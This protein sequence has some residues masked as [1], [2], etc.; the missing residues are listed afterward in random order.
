MAIIEK[1]KVKVK[2]NFRRSNFPG[3]ENGEIGG[4]GGKQRGEK[5][6]KNGESEDQAR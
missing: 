4:S 2:L 1:H 6:V 5:E 3:P